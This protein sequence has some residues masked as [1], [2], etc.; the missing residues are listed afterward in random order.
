MTTSMTLH[1]TRY[2]VHVLFRN[3]SILIIIMVTQV[4]YFLFYQMTS[5]SN[6]IERAA[7]KCDIDQLKREIEN[8]KLCS[9]DYHISRYIRTDLV[10]RLMKQEIDQSLSR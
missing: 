1:A 4:I 9:P 7:A 3:L 10:T 2:T 6:G 8:V 5:P